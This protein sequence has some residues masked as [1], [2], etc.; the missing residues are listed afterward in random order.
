MWN[1]R[2][3]LLD[4]EARYADLLEH[5]LYNAV[6]PGLSLDGQSYFYQNP[7]ADDGTHRRQ[8]WFGCACCPP[9]IARVMSQLPGYVYTVT[10]RRF[11]ESDGQHESIWVHL[12]ADNEA[13]IPLASGASV[14]L[15]QTT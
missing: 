11:P 7:L 12:F 2:M 3:L 13:S 1:W 6:L 5:T 4:G 8:A 10:A 15:R 9:N 14:G